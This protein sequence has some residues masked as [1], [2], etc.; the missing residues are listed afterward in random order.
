MAYRGRR[1][2]APQ[3]RHRRRIGP[4]AGRRPASATLDLTGPTGIRGKRDYSRRG[5]STR[6]GG[7]WLGRR[8]AAELQQ[9]REGQPGRPALPGQELHLLA[10]Q[11]PVFERQLRN[12][13]GETAP[14]DLPHIP[15]RT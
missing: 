3:R 7:E 15:R 10:D 6:Q 2:P 4:H 8:K 12:E 9:K 5:I 14:E 1:D 13:G 11:G